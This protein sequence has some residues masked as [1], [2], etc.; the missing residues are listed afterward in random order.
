MRRGG[1]QTRGPR[2]SVSRSMSWRWSGSTFVTLAGAIGVAVCALYAWRRRG[3][4][5]A[6]SLVV[7]LL[8]ATEWSLAHTLE[9]SGGNLATRQL[10]G[11]LRFIGTCLL[12]PACLI[13]MLQ[14]SGRIRRPSRS[15]LALL[16]IEPLVVLTTL[17]IPATRHLMISWD[18]RAP[19]ASPAAGG[20]G[21][22]A[23]PGPLYWVDF[24]YFTVLMWAFVV[25][26][27]VTL[28]RTSRMYR[29]QSAILFSALLAPL[30]SSTLYSLRIG[31]FGRLDLTPFA[32]VLTSAVLV[33]CVLGFSLLDLRPVA[34][35]RIFQTI[36]DGVVVLD[37]YGKVIDANLAAE[38]LLGQPLSQAVGQP[39]EQV[40]PA[41][42]AVIARQRDHGRD[43]VK[44]ARAAGGSYEVAISS[45]TD[46]LGQPTGQL[47]VAQIV[48][49]AGPELLDG[50]P[51]KLE[52]RPLPLWV[53]AP[54]VERIV[55]N[56]LANAARHT[57]PGT[58]VWVRVEPHDRGAVL[59][60]ED[61][62]PGVPAELREA[63][64]QPFRQGPNPAAYAPGLGVGLTLV[65]R[66]AELHGGRA[67]V[68][69]GPGHGASFR[70]LLPDAH[71]A[72][73]S[74]NGDGRVLGGRGPVPAG[75]VGR[76]RQVALEAAV[77]PRLA[78]GQAQRQHARPDRQGVVL[79][80]V[81]DRAGAHLGRDL[82]QRHRQ[83]GGGRQ[84]LAVGAARDLAAARDDVLDHG[85]QGRVLLL[86][87]G[88]QAGPAEDHHR[89]V[90]KGMVEYRAGQD[91]P[92]DQR[93]RDA[94][95]HPRPHAEAAA[96][97]PVQVQRLADPSVAGRQRVDLPVHGEGHMAQ[98]PLVQDGVH[99][100][101]VVPPALRQPPHLRAAGQLICA[102]G[103]LVH[104]PPRNTFYNNRN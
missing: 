23:R 72:D 80:L 65:H 101:P 8:A 50:R 41:W 7:A 66:F 64:F 73:S 68:E 94:D 74:G 1:P 24:V 84:L 83:H 61:A 53:D 34:R 89:A 79:F 10:G 47:L 38:R 86:E 71:H 76:D 88:D 25:I 77:G 45:L 93:D 40:L 85:P 42:A 43:T 90:L 36:A 33:W 19:G 63:I 104:G 32:F 6:A 78:G 56:L 87:V 16:A 82:E 22:S 96:G 48:N 75:D 70:V 69:D 31:P 100:R 13:F 59:V 51:V 30:L 35:S 26:L 92:V 81:A 62:G 91:Q 54:K 27:A 95:V 52:T 37:L 49:E 44:E 28:A 99:G 97:R 11:E 55:E 20:L 21:P 67:W 60:V 57:P 14:Y 39:V 29:R 102:V 12:P 98:E 3:S 4:P 9:L 18:P 46:S 58:P 2:W 17:A 15:M 103:P 5:A